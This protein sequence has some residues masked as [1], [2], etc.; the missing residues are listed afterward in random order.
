MDFD[1]VTGNL[2]DTENGPDYGDE[3]NLV[4]P[5]FNSG[6]NRV[7]GIWEDNG[8]SLGMIVK[9]TRGEDIFV[10]F[11]GR[12]KYSNPE[13]TWA[14]SIGPTAL[15]FLDSDK[16]GKEYENDM[17]VGDFHSGNIYHFD[18]V[19]NRKALSLEGLL[20]DKMANTGDEIKTTLSG[21][22]FGG[23]TDIEVGP[24]GYL[25]VLAAYQ[26]FND[27]TPDKPGKRCISYTSTTQGTIFRIMPEADTNT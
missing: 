5:G 23:V 1:P 16:L 19:K 3:I 7:Q 2:W 10:D 17:F 9:N 8:G 4:E 24:D 25:Y 18:L 6:W 13:F 14:A 15:K 12:G 26:T 11:N 27:C 21:Q 22:G 20:Q